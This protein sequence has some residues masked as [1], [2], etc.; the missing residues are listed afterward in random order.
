[1]KK[2]L[3]SLFAVLLVVG[4][5]SPFAAEASMENYYPA[6]LDDHWAAE[7]MYQLID[8]D[9]MKG[10]LKAGVMYAKPK[11]EITRAEV[12]ALLVR[13]LDLKT[14]KQGKTFS[15]VPKGKWFYEPIMTASA[16]GIVNGT[17]ETTFKPD[18]SITREEL[19]TMIV[20]AF[21]SVK[22]IDFTQ[23]TPANF[24]DK[25]T[26]S[27][28]AVPFINKASAVEIVQGSNG[29]FSPK[30]T[31]TRAETSTMLLNALLT[32]ST[33]L[34]NDEELIN[35]VMNNENEL[36]K[37]YQAETFENTYPIIDQYTLGFLHAV[38]T[39]SNDIWIDYRDQGYDI[40]IE[41]VEPTATGVVGKNTRMAVV[42]VTGLSYDVTISY[43]G[44]IE[45]QWTDEANYYF[46]RKVDGEWKIYSQQ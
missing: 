41:Q 38:L 33:N 45:A 16:L 37:H 32:E 30:N 42:E 20:R 36:Y 21:E 1:M 22:T 12:T 4:T 23:G 9:I 24:S 13:S 8:A 43:D 17:S 18:K 19:A 39:E 15:D 2:F 14:T 5:I 35:L 44:K 11:K 31:A 34:P 25:N 3:A 27:T 28:W 7:T 10:Y 6:D 29:K 26:F 40:A 46:L